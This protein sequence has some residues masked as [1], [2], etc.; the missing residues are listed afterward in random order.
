MHTISRADIATQFR[1]LVG[2]MLKKFIRSG[3]EAED[4]MQEGFCGLFRAYDRFDP[5]MGVSFFTYAYPWVFSAMQNHVEGFSGP[6]RASHGVWTRRRLADEKP[7]YP[8]VDNRRYGDNN[9]PFSELLNACV[10]DRANGPQAALIQK[11]D[12]QIV[13]EAIMF[14]SL[15]QQR[16]I[17]SHFFEDRTFAEIALEMGFTKQYAHQVFEDAIATL[18]KRL[19][20]KIT[21]V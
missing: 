4:L 14:L 6:V 16:V 17:L 7:E 1:D 18:R 3:V 12:G 15:V 20:V 8:R 5:S 11:L 19:R 2:F 9:D 13:Y 21:T 10:G